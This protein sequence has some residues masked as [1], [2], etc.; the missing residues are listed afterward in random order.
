MSAGIPV[1]AS[2]FP[3]WRQI[4]SSAR[5]GLLVDPQDPRAIAEAMRWILKHPAEA[6]SMGQRGRLAVE[7]TYN[8]DIEVTKL[9]DLYSKLL[10]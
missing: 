9:I 3:L 8:W 2:D 5:C 1:I 6:E 10:P 7:R 4:V